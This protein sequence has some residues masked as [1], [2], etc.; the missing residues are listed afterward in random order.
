MR[1]KRRL[2]GCCVSIPPRVGIAIRAFSD[3]V[4]LS[5]FVGSLQACAFLYGDPDGETESAARCG[6]AFVRAYWLCHA[7]RGENVG[8]CAP[9]NLRQRVFDSLDSL[10]WVRGRVPFC[11]STLALRCFP[12]GERWGLRAPKPAP[13]SQMWK[14]HCGLSGLSSFDSRQSTSLPNLA[15]TAILEPT[16]PRPAA[17]GYTERPARV[18]FMLGRV[19]LY[20]DDLNACQRP[21][22]KRP[23]ALKSRVACAKRCGCRHCRP[24]AKRCGSGHCPPA[25]HGFDFLLVIDLTRFGYYNNRWKRKGIKRKKKEC[26]PQ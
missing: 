26:V 5:D 14:P 4:R 18:Q 13:K 6:Y 24:C 20:S 25:L 21:D 1:K 12:R 2:A 7:F 22:S 10:H 19:G 3:A 16:R 9:P 23:Q 15:I 8:G 17:P 11:A